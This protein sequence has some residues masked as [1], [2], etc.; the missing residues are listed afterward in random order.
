MSSIEQSLPGL[1][2]PLVPGPVFFELTLDGK[3]RHK[4]RHRSR[5]VQPRGKKPF[6]HNYPDPETEAFEKTLATAARLKMRSRPPSEK[7]LILL[8]IADREVP[9]SWSKRERQAAL[10]ARIL[11]TG[12]PDWDNHGKI[13]DA[14]NGIVW[15]DDAQ[16]IDARVIKR[17]H[18]RP[19][20]TIVV[21]EYVEQRG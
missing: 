13:T 17:F 8:V 9:A 18:A 12:K 1:E 6:I 19:A 3:P 4:G 20:L 7:P 11:P 15:R 2:L 10:D 16:V 21:R 5:I 14:L